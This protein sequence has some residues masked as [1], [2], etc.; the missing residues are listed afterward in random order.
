[1]AQSR[2]VIWAL[3][4]IS[5]TAP[6]NSGRS[7]YRFSGQ[8]CFQQQSSKWYCPRGS[9]VSKSSSYSQ[10]GTQPMTWKTSMIPGKDM[11]IGGFIPAFLERQ[12]YFSSFLWWIISFQSVIFSYSKRLCLLWE[13]LLYSSFGFF[14]WRKEDN[15]FSCRHKLKK[16]LYMNSLFKSL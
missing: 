1:M 12:N 10:L 11:F 6:S 16:L 4:R 13:S 8:T 9:K 3:L 14:S 2:S 7:W 5:S 15:I